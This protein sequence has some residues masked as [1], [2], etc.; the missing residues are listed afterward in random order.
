MFDFDIVSPSK[1][2][3]LSGQAT[4]SLSSSVALGIKIFLK[5]IV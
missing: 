4:L 3:P 5:N 2:L 1:S